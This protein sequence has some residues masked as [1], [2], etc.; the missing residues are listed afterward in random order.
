MPVRNMG[1][2]E[3]YIKSGVTDMNGARKRQQEWC[4]FLK[5]NLFAD[6]NNPNQKE[7]EQIK[8]AHI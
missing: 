6:T 3:K 4:I 7:S 2:L 8:D 1:D 5:T